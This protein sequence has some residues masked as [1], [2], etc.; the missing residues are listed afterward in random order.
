MEFR[1]WSVGGKKGE[2]TEKICFMKAEVAHRTPHEEKESRL[3][4]RSVYSMAL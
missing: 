2:T 3:K 4:R 1:H